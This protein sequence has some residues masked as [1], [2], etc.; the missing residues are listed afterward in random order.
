MIP[1]EGLSTL[2]SISRRVALKD[3]IKAGCGTVETEQCL[4]ADR[5]SGLEDYQPFF[6]NYNDGR[7]LPSSSSLCCTASANT[8]LNQQK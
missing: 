3:K 2:A 4:L 8:S 7:Y 1:R 5:R 6:V